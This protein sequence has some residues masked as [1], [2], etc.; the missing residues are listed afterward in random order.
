MS[1]KETR[2]SYFD[3]QEYIPCVFHQNEK[4]NWGIRPAGSIGFSKP[5]HRYGNIEY[6]SNKRDGSNNIEKTVYVVIPGAL[7]VFLLIFFAVIFGLV[8]PTV[9]QGQATAPPRNVSAANKETPDLLSSWQATGFLFPE[10]DTRYLTDSDMVAL[11]TI[12]DWPVASL[13][14]MAI[15]EIYARHNYLFNS[16]EYRSFFSRYSWYDG[17]LSMENAASFFNEIESA[18]IRY[19]ISIKN[20]YK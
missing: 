11:S 19:L 18:N 10:S 17:Y 4:T 16:E 8:K 7:I 13:V 14:Q 9:W 6:F 3:P 1:T 2:M 15:N 5:K 12:D 20:S